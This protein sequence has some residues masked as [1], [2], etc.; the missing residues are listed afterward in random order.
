MTRTSHELPEGKLN[1]PMLDRDEAFEGALVRQKTLFKFDKKDVMLG[2]TDREISQQVQN[3][4]QS[5]VKDKAPSGNK[6][7]SKNDLPSYLKMLGRAF[8]SAVE[9][10]GSA[11]PEAQPYAGTAL[12]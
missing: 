5:S 11:P 3:S 2:Q 1:S 10:Q 6:C 9:P 4:L 8:L 7:A 12:Q